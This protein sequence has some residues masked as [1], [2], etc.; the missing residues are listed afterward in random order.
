MN[1]LLK[2]LGLNLSTVKMAYGFGR[3]QGRKILRGAL[4]FP[5]IRK[6]DLAK[7]NDADIL[8][9]REAWLDATVA[10]VEELLDLDE[11]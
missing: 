8:A 3:D 1:E 6:A 11:D 9:K 2:A 10:L 4:I 5:G 7:Y